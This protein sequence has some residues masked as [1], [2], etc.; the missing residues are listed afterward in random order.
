MERTIRVTGRGRISLKPDMMRLIIKISEVHKDYQETIEAS[1]ERTQTL[2]EA[3]GNAGFDPKD[4]KTLFFSVDVENEGYYDKNNN[5]KQKFAGYR[6]THNLR[7]S[8]DLDN[9][10][11]GK[12]LY[13]LAKCGVNAEISIGY[14]VKDPDAAKDL[15]L[16][17]AVKDSA[18]KA[19]TLAK[20]SGV[21]LGRVVSID[22]SWGE[23]DI[24]GRAVDDMKIGG[25]AFSKTM[26]I[27]MDIEADD[28]DVTDTVTIVWEI[29]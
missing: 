10:K 25:A 16:E 9:G 27:D 14:T 26:S 4:L 7:I 22:Y 28:I 2:R 8:F 19:S 21:E 15:L 11:L 23:L 18:N 24:Y 20:A 17:S 5:W 1:S 13:Q 29:Q 3:L 12:A 6:F